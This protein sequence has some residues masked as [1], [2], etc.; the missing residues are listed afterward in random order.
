MIEIIVIPIVC[1]GITAVSAFVLLLLKDRW[2]EPSREQ[3]DE[4]SRLFLKRLK[5]PDFAAVERHFGHALPE[6]L[7]ALHAD[8]QELLRSDFFVAPTQADAENECWEIACYQPVDEQSIVDCWPGN[9]EYLAFADDGCGNEYLIN[10]KETDPAVFFR[11]HETNELIQ[12]CDR[13]TEFMK[14]PRLGIEIESH[15]SAG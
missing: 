13:L 15:D 5:S 14:W 9:E 11:D 4:A 2:F 8:Q 7:I 10:P 6:C 12:V 3:I 1:I